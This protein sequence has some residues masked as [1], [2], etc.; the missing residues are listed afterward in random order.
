MSN[1][2]T[3][4]RTRVPPSIGLGAERL[5]LLALR[6]PVT[7]GV[8]AAILVGLALLGIGKLQV[9]DSLSQFFRS[10]STE[11][12]QY[13]TVAKRF[14]SSEYDILAV[15]TGPVLERTSLEA[16]RNLATDLQL[17]D[18]A[19]GLVSIFSARTA[20]TSGRLPAPLFPEPLPEGEAY[21]RLLDSVRSN[22]ILKDKL[23]ASNGALTLMVLAL[24]P[25]AVESAHLAAAVHDIQSTIDSD[26][27]GSGLKVQLTGV[28]VMQLEIRRAIERDRVLYNAAGLLVGCLIAA[29]F[30][31]RVSFML[32][33]AGPPLVSILLALG[34]FGWLD[35]RL[36]IFL[37]MMTPLI[38]VISFSDSMQLTFH[39]RTRLIAGTDKREAIRDA[40]L[41]VGP[42]CVLTHATAAISFIALQASESDLIRDFGKAGLLATAIALAAVLTLMPPLGLLLLGRADA[43]ARSARRA[44]P[45]VSVLRRFCALIAGWMVHRPGLYTGCGLALTG[46][47]AIGYLQLQPRY[48]LAD[49]VPG[50]EQAVAASDRLDRD[51]TGAN[52]IDVMIQIPPG[53]SLYS[54]RTLGVVAEVHRML[55][56]QPGVGNVWSLETLRAWLAEN[57]QRADPD[58]IKGYVDALPNFLVRRFVSAD[59][60]ALLVTG[61]VRDVDASDLLPVVQDLD[62]TL[63]AV[64]QGNPGYTVAVTSLSAIAARNSARMIDKL[65]R[66]IT[67]E[68]V[69]IAAAIGVAFRSLR[70][71][72][73]SILPAIFP[74]VATGSLLWLTDG[75]LRFASVV[76]LTVALGLGLSATIHFLNRMTLDLVTAE[77]P[78]LAV[79]QATVQM[80]PP[81]ILTTVVLSCA[82][83]ITIL[84]NLP[85]LRLFGWLSALAMLFALVADLLILRPVITLLYRYD[86]TGT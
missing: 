3:E 11:F 65:S 63:A 86:R 26:L 43:F 85:M 23:L 19:R 68:V 56:R 64:R 34:A 79:E 16:L 25:E 31:R 27:A 9:D 36:N 37:N 52:P 67:V 44:D 57:G 13:E 32:I 80:G 58:T 77:G 62:R 66:G 38:M 24:A 4:R 42:A 69:F 22:E 60:R 46:L 7:V 15:V 8:A 21:Q 29:V 30:F 70:V 61:R 47:L 33:A 1:K 74:V 28:P 2:V 40:L 49:E 51:L 82:F 55:G 83:A 39:V 71:M 81:L 5:G 14:P 12:R 72:C 17:V 10:D 54:A 75:G 35:L 45:G 76:A 59:E 53:E 48:R 78:G 18:G 41:V 6:H 20:P 73:A 50:H 84:S